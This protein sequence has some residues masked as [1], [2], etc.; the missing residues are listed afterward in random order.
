MRRLLASLAA[1]IGL[2]PATPSLAGP[3]SPQAAPAAWVAYAGLVNQAIAGQL[4]GTDPAAVRLHDYLDQI[5]GASPDSGFRLPIQV[6]VDAK[7]VITRIDFTP[8]AHPEPDA[9]LWAL[10]VG[11]RLP[12]VPPKD[13]LLPIRL[14]IGLEPGPTPTDKAVSPRKSF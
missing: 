4:G 7:G 10:L 3:V 12:Q 2:S 1:V 14:S 13:M 6:W 5:P 8:F 9:D 11:H